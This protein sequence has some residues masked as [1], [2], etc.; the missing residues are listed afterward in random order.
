MS[1]Q[2]FTLPDVGEGVAEGELVQWL[3]AE[4]ESVEEDQPL[5]EVETDKALVE[6]PS[7]YE[8]TVETLHVDE[9]EVVPVGTVIVTVRVDD[10]EDGGDDALADEEPDAGAESAAEPGAESAGDADAGAE[11]AA[12]TAG[13][14]A[15]R[16]RTFA[17]PH[18]RR[19]ARERGVDIS[20][21]AGSGPGGR[22]TEADVRA[23]AE[24]G[25]ETAESGAETGAEAAGPDAQADEATA[26]GADAEPTT[27][28]A[29]TAPDA[30]TRER[31]LATPATRRVARELDVD[32]DS[33]P[34]V[35]ERSGDA[36]VT[37]AAVR[38]YAGA[39][40]SAQAADAATVAGDEAT[41]D[42][43]ERVPYRG[44]RR[45][46]GER[47]AE[48]AYTAPHVTHHD[49]A[50]ASALVEWRADLRAR[51]AERGADLTYLPFVLKALVVAL[52]E[53]PQL[54]AQL[55]EAAG[56]IVR[57]HYYHLGVAVATDAG[58][59]VPVVRDVDEKGLVELATS[60]EDLAAQ[61]R[62]RT[63]APEDLRGSTFSVTNFG[64]VGGEY[65]TP[66]INYPEVAILGLGRLEKRPVVED[67]AVVAKPTLP[68]SLSVDHRVVDGA[69]AARFTN[70][71]IEL[72]ENP[73]LLLLD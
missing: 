24:D 69:E 66:I 22:V 64:A 72:I 62:E 38:E 9:G 21:V 5:A 20:A 44:V 41:G 53:F 59:M 17:P 48:S 30:A 4:G 52:R 13:G 35:E 16:E 10:G 56:E 50:D 6:V 18:V 19:L 34:A 39:Q 36:F 3:V 55:D 40:E 68:L 51:A 63:V 27:A 1:L 47:M 32:L 71:L 12:E 42:R 61:A 33:V 57:K 65:A 49:T 8:G 23:A 67:D 28:S 70:R 54:N 15:A 14:G 37:A 31:T 25:T 45:T 73:R 60:I 58:L 46:V 7:P 29:P 43:E 26:A 2:E 11:S